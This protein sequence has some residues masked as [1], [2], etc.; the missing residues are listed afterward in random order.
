MDE[1]PFAGT[2]DKEIHDLDLG[3]GHWLDWS[4]YMGETCGGIISHVLSCELKKKLKAEHGDL[5]WIEMNLCQGAF[6]IKGT[7]GHQTESKRASWTLSGSYEKPTLS[8]S[9]LCHCGDHGFI[10]EGKWI[11]A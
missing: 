1:H 5:P 3:D 10:R 4:T 11:R 2:E 9:F 7:K 8:P 6:T